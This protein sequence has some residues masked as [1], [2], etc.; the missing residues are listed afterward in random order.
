MP[1][2]HRLLATTRDGYLAM[3]PCACCL[4]L[5]FGR[6]YWR[7]SRDEFDSFYVCL[8]ELSSPAGF[9]R[10]EAEPGLALLSLAGD[11]QA[12]LMTRDELISMCCLLERGAICLARREL[13]ASYQAVPERAE[14]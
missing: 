8:G 13:E 6:Q 7:L 9:A 14:G 3:A 1:E 2:Q 12:V 11:H 4:H 5:R 10:N